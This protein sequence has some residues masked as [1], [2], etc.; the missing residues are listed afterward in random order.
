MALRNV[1]GRVGGPLL[2]VAVFVGALLIWEVWARHEGSFLVPPPS[3]VLKTA[4]RV[5]PT[6]D[7][8]TMSRPA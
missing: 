8:W 2:G 6:A 1:L 3:E 4:W 5:W 7:F